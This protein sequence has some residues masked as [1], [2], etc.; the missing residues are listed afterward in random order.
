MH[1]DLIKAIDLI[2]A[3]VINGDTFIDDDNREE[4]ERMMNRWQKQLNSY[5]KL[6]K[7]IKDIEKKEE[8]D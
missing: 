6:S 1:K 5:E 3:S 7:E 8:D 4:L 2:D